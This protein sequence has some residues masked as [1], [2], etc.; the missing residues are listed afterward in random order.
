MLAQNVHNC[1]LVHVTEREARA[2]A[3]ASNA[4]SRRVPFDPRSGGFQEL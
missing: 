2:E 1:E 4:S 3:D